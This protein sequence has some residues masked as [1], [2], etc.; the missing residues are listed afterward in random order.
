MGYQGDLGFNVL[1]LGGLRDVMQ[2][3]GGTRN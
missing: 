2:V 1:M 3:I